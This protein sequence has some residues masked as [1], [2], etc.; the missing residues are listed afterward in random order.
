M[1]KSII[2]RCCPI[3]QKL[4][5]SPIMRFEGGSAH[6]EQTNA[7]YLDNG[8]Y[9]AG[10]CAADAAVFQPI[11][12]FQRNGSAGRRTGCNISGLFVGGI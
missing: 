12:R 2:V 7:L 5:I 9:P 10:F 6:E 11:G 3:L 4:K 8:G 1:E